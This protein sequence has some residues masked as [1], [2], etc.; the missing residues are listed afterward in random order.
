MGH[1]PTPPVSDGGDATLVVVQATPEDAE[2]AHALGRPAVFVQQPGGP[3][4]EL[5]D[6]HALL[7]SLDYTADVFEEFVVRVLKPLSPQAVVTL[8]E[9]AR[10]SADRANDL[11][12][13]PRITA[14]EVTARLRAAVRAVRERDAGRG[15]Q[16]EVTP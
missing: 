7:H 15:T 6:D 13:V 16:E 5:L 4:E 12:G 9:S 14:E 11:L 1:E 3:V 2:A 8:E 10:A